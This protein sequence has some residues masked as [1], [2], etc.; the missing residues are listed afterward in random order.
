M[1]CENLLNLNKRDLINII[2]NEE[3]KKNSI[4]S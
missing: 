4:D 1:I 2:K 3:E